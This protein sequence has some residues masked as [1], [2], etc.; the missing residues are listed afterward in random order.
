M[1]IEN[2]TIN[3]IM[4]ALG[5]IDLTMRQLK[6]DEQEH[7]VFHSKEWK[8]NKRYK[9]L[10]VQWD[11]LRKLRGM[12]INSM[13]ALTIDPNNLTEQ[14]EDCNVDQIARAKNMAKR[15][16]QELSNAIGVV[17][18]DELLA[19]EI[20]EGTLTTYHKGLMF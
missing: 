13:V 11:A 12:R 16:V 20:I 17:F 5:E 15:C 3:E 9:A 4:L 10:Q 6:K 1:K 8:P 2:I 14:V 19:A 7:V 18:E